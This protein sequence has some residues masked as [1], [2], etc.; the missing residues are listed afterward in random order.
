MESKDII[1]LTDEYMNSLDDVSNTNYVKNNDL[2]TIRFNNIIYYH[3]IMPDHVII[4]CVY[5][6]KS[7]ASLQQFRIIRDNKLLTTN[8]LNEY[9]A[10]NEVLD[11]ISNHTDPNIIAETMIWDISLMIESIVPSKK[12]Q[13][14]N[15]NAPLPNDEFKYEA[16]I[17]DDLHEKI[18]ISDSEND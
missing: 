16:K 4:S 5:N 10:N 11:S 3:I 2:K 15:N 9:L 1:I 14:K 12:I 8:T 6:N 7:F 18:R 13:Y 17:R